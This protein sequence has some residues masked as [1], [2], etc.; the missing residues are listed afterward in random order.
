V[1]PLKE[2]TEDD[3]SAAVREAAADALKKIGA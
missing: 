3:G 1:A 2:A